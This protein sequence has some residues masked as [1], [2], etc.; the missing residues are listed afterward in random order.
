ML[1]VFQRNGKWEVSACNLWGT[2][3][4]EDFYIAQSEAEAEAY[5]EMVKAETKKFRKKWRKK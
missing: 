1:R 4:I 3:R 5:I 2:P